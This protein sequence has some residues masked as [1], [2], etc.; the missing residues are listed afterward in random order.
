MHTREL[1]RKARE[2]GDGGTND[3]LV[4]D[5]PRTSEMQVWFLSEH[6]AEMPPVYTKT[7]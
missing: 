4:S 7:A 5:V 3:L 2:P 6:V 1:A